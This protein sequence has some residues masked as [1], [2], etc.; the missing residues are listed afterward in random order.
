[1]S[2]KKPVE[3]FSEVDQTINP[4][5]ETERKKRE[6]AE[7]AFRGQDL[8]QDFPV[9]AVFVR[10]K[11]DTEFKSKASREVTFLCSVD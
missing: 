10:W 2:T 6:I 3:E 4:R 1:M 5:T 8:K 7:S 9:D 11:R